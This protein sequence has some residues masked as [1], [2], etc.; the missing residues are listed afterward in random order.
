MLTC[1]ERIDWCH[2][3]HWLLLWPL[4][5]LVKLG[6][7]AK[8]VKME[9]FGEQR[10]TA[11]PFG[12]VSA[13]VFGVRFQRSWVVGTAVQIRRGCQLLRLPLWSRQAVLSWC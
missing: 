7:R 13:A 4:E 3:R 8:P 1:P 5:G 2:K 12:S 6:L 9:T 11:L 10:S